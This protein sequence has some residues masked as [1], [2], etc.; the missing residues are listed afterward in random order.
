MKDEHEQQLIKKYP[1][2]FM[3]YAKDPTESLMYFGCEC[4]SGWYELLDR[5]CAKLVE[6]AKLENI[7]VSFSQVKEKFGA[8]RIY[9]SNGSDALWKILSDAEHES[10]SICEWCGAPGSLDVLNRWHATLCPSCKE[11]RREQQK[12]RF[13]DIHK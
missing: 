8:L 1:S 7:D 11:K 9:L 10:E 12:I 5:T 4:G 6:Q 3:D 13:A 2:L